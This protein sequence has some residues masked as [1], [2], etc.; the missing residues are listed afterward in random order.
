MV[1]LPLIR[2][3]FEPVNCRHSFSSS[4]PRSPANDCPISPAVPRRRSRRLKPTIYPFANDLISKPFKT[5]QKQPFRRPAVPRRRSRGASA[6]V[7]LSPCP[8]KVC[9]FSACAARA[10]L[11]PQGN[12]SACSDLGQTCRP[13]RVPSFDSPAIPQPFAVRP[14]A[15]PKCPEKPLFLRVR[16][17]VAAFFA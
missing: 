3:V 8:V 12:R 9:N 2:R 7:G 13:W 1:L 14:V 11:A 5:L 10:D 17:R 4:P 16:F 6:P 15:V